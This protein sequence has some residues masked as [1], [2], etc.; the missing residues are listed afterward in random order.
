MKSKFLHLIKH[1]YTAWF[2]VCLL[3]AFIQ[4]VTILNYSGEKV[5]ENA[6]FYFSIG[7]FGGDFNPHWFGYGSF[8]MYLLYIVY[9]ILYIPAYLF[10][11]F[12][13]LSEY[14]MQMFYNGYFNLVARY[15]FALFGV[16]GVFL[17]GKLAKENKIS[18][19][20]CSRVYNV[21]CF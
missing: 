21:I 9:I 18:T 12:S 19:P 20:F 4:V 15:V 17:L 3:L 6:I 5:D 10:N 16:L 8:G 14:A 2:F 11:G 1:R 13:S 7:F